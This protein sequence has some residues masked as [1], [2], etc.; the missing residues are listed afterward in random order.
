M[1]S[2]SPGEVS[3]LVEMMCYVF[4]AGAALLGFLLSCLR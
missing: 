4:T 3:A 1:Y 2:A